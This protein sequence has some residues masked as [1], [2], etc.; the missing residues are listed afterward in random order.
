[1]A[2]AMHSMPIVACQASRG[3]ALAETVPARAAALLFGFGFIWAAA[4]LWL[5]P[6]HGLAPSVMLTKMLLSVFMVTLGVCLT[7]VATQKLQSRL[8]FDT[9]HR[10]I[11]LV[12]SLPRGRSHIVRV[13]N[14]EEVAEANVS[15]KLL[16]LIGRNGKI[17]A[18]LPL[19]GAHARLDAIAHLRSHAI[20]AY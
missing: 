6:G 10:Q 2:Y 13:I 7:Q 19:D 5:V 1:M 15:D 8:Q 20:H 4:G 12:E 14:F 11:Q 17:L 3:R 18:E 9:R 16:V